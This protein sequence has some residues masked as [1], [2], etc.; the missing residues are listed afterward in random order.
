M[1]DNIATWKWDKAKWLIQ[2]HSPGMAKKIAKWKF[3]S[4]GP[5]YGVNCYLRQFFIP[6]KKVRLAH[7]L[8]GLEYK[9]NPNRVKAGKQAAKSHPIE[10]KGH[11]IRGH[12]S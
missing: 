8:L 5:C 1:S 4:P 7:K 6:V 10:N 3:S 2:V 12:E 11:Q 9:K